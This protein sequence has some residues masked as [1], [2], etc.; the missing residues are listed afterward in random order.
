[1]NVKPKNPY[2]KKNASKPE[3][4][5]TP[6]QSMIT[7]PLKINLHNPLS[8]PVPCLLKKEK[9]LIFV[10][11]LKNAKA[12]GR[13]S[14][15][16]HM[17]KD[18]IFNEYDSQNNK[19][20]NLYI[21]SQQKAFLIKEIGDNNLSIDN[22][23]KDYIN[24]TNIINLNNEINQTNKTS[25]HQT[26]I[27]KKGKLS[28]YIIKTTKKPQVSKSSDPF[29]KNRLFQN[30]F[31]ELENASR[32][33]NTKKKYSEQKGKSEYSIRIPGMF[34]SRSKSKK[35]NNTSQ[36]NKLI[37][38]NEIT[39]KRNQIFPVPNTNQSIKTYTYCGNGMNGN[40]TFTSFIPPTNSPLTYCTNMSGINPEFF[41]PI[42]SNLNG[43]FDNDYDDREDDFTICYPTNRNIMIGGRVE[44]MRRFER[45]E[46]I[47]KY[48]IEN[49]IKI[50]RWYK[51]LFD[52]KRKK[53]ILL[54]SMLRGYLLR[55]RIFK[56]IKLFYYLLTFV[57]HLHNYYLSVGKKTWR[58]EVFDRIKIKAVLDSKYRSF[59]NDSHLRKVK[60]NKEYKDLYEKALTEIEVMKNYLYQLNNEKERNK[61]NDSNNLKEYNKLRNN[62]PKKQEFETKMKQQEIAQYND[63]FKI[64]IENNIQIKNNTL[65]NRNSFI[66]R[67]REEDLKNN[68]QIQ[69]KEKEFN[70]DN[71]SENEKNQRM[72]TEGDYDPHKIKIKNIFTE[73]IE[74]QYKDKSMFLYRRGPRSRTEPTRC[75]P[76]TKNNEI[77]SNNDNFINEEH[78]T[79]KPFKIESNEKRSSRDQ[80]I[81]NDQ[82]PTTEKD[83]IPSSSSKDNNDTINE[84]RRLSKI[85]QDEHTY[86]SKA[87]QRI[88][89]KYDNCIKTNKKKFCDSNSLF[90]E[91]TQE[92]PKGDNI[93]NQGNDNIIKHRFQKA[94][95]RS[96]KKNQDDSTDNN[97]LSETDPK[98]N[99]TYKYKK[100]RDIEKESNPKEKS[101]NYLVTSNN[102]SLILSKKKEKIAISKEKELS[103][104]NKQKPKNKITRE[105]KFLIQ[106]EYQKIDLEELY[107]SKQKQITV[108][109]GKSLN[110]KASKKKKLILPQN[111]FSIEYFSRPEAQK[112][113]YSLSN[114]KYFTIKAK[115]N[116]KKKLEIAFENEMSVIDKANGKKAK[117]SLKIS[118]QNQIQFKKE[119]LEKPKYTISQ[120]NEL[121]FRKKKNKNNIENCE[122]YKIISDNNITYSNK[123]FTPTIETISK[124]INEY[125][126]KKS[127]QLSVYPENSICIKTKQKIKK[128]KLSISH[129]NCINYESPEKLPNK[130]TKRAPGFSILGEKKQKA[131]TIILPQ[132]KP[133]FMS[134]LKEPRQPQFIVSQI[135]QTNNSFITYYG[136]K[137]Q[138]S[139]FNKIKPCTIK[140]N[141]MMLFSKRFA[142]SPAK[143]IISPNKETYSYRPSSAYYKNKNNQNN[144]PITL[145]NFNISCIKPKR[146]YEIDYNILGVSYKKKKNSDELIQ[147]DKEQNEIKTHYSICSGLNVI[148]VINNNEN[149]IEEGNVIRNTE[150]SNNNLPSNRSLLNR[151]YNK[152]FYDLIGNTNTSSNNLLEGESNK[153]LVGNPNISIVSIENYILGNMII[154]SY[155][156]EIIQ[157]IK[158]KNENEENVK[159]INENK[160]V[161]KREK[162]QCSIEI[163]KQN[164]ILIANNQKDIQNHFS[165]TTQPLSN[166]L[167]KAFLPFFLLK[168]IP[169]TCKKMHFKT[170]I[171][172]LDKILSNELSRNLIPK[173]RRLKTITSKSLSDNEVAIRKNMIVKASQN[174]N[175]R[176]LKSKFS[177][178]K[179]T[180]IISKIIE[181][182][183]LSKKNIFSQEHQ[184]TLSYIQVKPFKIKQRAEMPNS[185]IKNLSFS[186]DNQNKI[187]HINLFNQ[188]YSNKYGT[189]RNYSEIFTPVKRIGILKKQIIYVDKI[190][191]RIAFLKWKKKCQSTQYYIKEKKI[192]L[193][194][195]KKL[196]EVIRDN[197]FYY[198]NIE[199][200]FNRWLQ[201]I[202]P[203]KL[204][205][206][207]RRKLKCCLNSVLDAVRLVNTIRDKLKLRFYFK[208]M[209]KMLEKN[210]LVQSHTLENIHSQSKGIRVKIMSKGKSPLS[211]TVQYSSEKKKT[212]SNNSSSDKIYKGM[213]V[214][215]KYVPAGNKNKNVLLFDSSLKHDP[216]M[217]EKQ[218]ILLI[219]INKQNKKKYF[220]KF[221]DQGY[222]KKI[223]LILIM[224]S[225]LIQTKK[226][227]KISIYELIETFYPKSNFFN[228]PE[229]KFR[230]Y[231][232]R[233]NKI[234]KGACKF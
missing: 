37:N 45:Y 179:T 7:T 92:Q 158:N 164:E 213:K 199:S 202:H 231:F 125:K 46:L 172:G 218:K 8:K 174:V 106:N 32:N 204:I 85:V 56:H 74:P 3:K 168:Q 68:N 27:H 61:S 95:K 73:R 163:S 185:H 153:S 14:L 193:I 219:I 113:N 210:K 28:S 217:Y 49:V 160:D 182:L 178:W 41:S 183:N 44:L 123:D 137:K 190:T 18:A 129:P 171:E 188:N 139:S 26:I 19:Y 82:S 94:H 148:E 104:S 105:N 108:S 144:K 143:T 175:K 79:M 101:N 184:L 122:K 170:F 42:K 198:V 65:K 33:N 71:S 50:Q 177:K 200:Y 89:G 232:S 187:N 214:Y 119:K 52:F 6:N 186:S 222:K 11:S 173:T 127:L 169:I 99:Y 150:D 208:K 135:K 48:K 35:V 209:K 118:E 43:L 67:E 132:K 111:H 151:A 4:K 224:I 98:N 220:M 117:K 63:I 120:E 39:G 25:I 96:L 121:S 55:D 180:S 176:Y 72:N 107:Q 189:Y 51:S 115:K 226:N 70:F 223:D 136:K 2:I 97:D 212:K 60:K 59:M 103:I 126:K 112:N 77:I 31:E 12:K 86:K 215:K 47:K 80:K 233:W 194:K 93:E 159:N 138:Q 133:Q 134:F 191:K 234:T 91:I 38:N 145:T 40:N 102:F 181:N 196:G 229:Y 157:N 228:K 128:P 64:T 1:M 29:T 84:E 203:S 156:F 152:Y 36:N 149:T 109:Q 197:I 16:K 124:I 155:S 140:I 88:K 66:K 110:I 146:I 62:E 87:L 161:E 167:S 9:E 207:K 154:T 69:K 142:F 34:Q 131:F 216:S 100:G 58:K 141:D 221:K 162:R 17:N 13:F 75:L 24:T 83:S 205:K 76:I 53:I 165:Q 5:N 195:Y 78:F 225:D 147:T 90:K 116:K 23:S 211:R 130:I 206:I 20:T 114:E 30:S 21:T 201:T 15:S 81:P 54:Q 227:T 230:K 10:D 57:M 192:I 22:K 166:L